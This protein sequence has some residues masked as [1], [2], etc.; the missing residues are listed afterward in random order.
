M[1]IKVMSL[2]WEH[3]RATGGDLLVLL[4]IADHAHDDGGGAWPSVETL[5]KMARL[6]ERQVQRA[7][8]HLERDLHELGVTY[9]GGRRKTSR[10]RIRLDMLKGNGDRM[11]PFSAETVT[12]T[13][14]NGDM[15]VTRS[16]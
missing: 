14:G 16:V 11:S 2:V 8:R 9:G 10:Y 7:L 12:F 13:T 4:A 1:S 6:T 15:G 3:S 5:A